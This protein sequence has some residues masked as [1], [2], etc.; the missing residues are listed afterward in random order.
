MPV[1][2]KFFLLKLVEFLVGM[3]RLNLL[4]KK[5]SFWD[6]IWKENGCP[7]SG[8]LRK[9]LKAA[10]SMKFIVSKDKLIR[11]EKLAEALCNS[12]NGDFWSLVHQYHGNCKLPGSNVM[13]L[14]WCILLIYVDSF[15]T[16]SL[17]LHILA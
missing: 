17:Q 13:L 11:S 14:E 3:T 8:V 7:S 4:D 16:S 1:F 9:I 10:T 15:S 5:L 2:P 12:S 6:R